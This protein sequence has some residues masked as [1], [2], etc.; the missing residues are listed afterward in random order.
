MFNWYFVKIGD[1]YVVAFCDVLQRS[2]SNF[3]ELYKLNTDNLIWIQV[4]KNNKRFW[5]VYDPTYIYNNA[6]YKQEII[7]CENNNPFRIEGV[8][9]PWC[10]TLKSPNMTQW[11]HMKE[12][13]NLDLTTG[14]NVV[15]SITPGPHSMDTISIDCELDYIKTPAHEVFSSR[16]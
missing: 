2:A 11:L 9:N 7:N 14:T 16:L 12:K 5:C 1:I 15:C 6:S 3:K 4:V 8:Y 10:Y 13:Y